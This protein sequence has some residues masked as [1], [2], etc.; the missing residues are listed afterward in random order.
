[1]YTHI[2]PRMVIN[3]LLADDC[4]QEKGKQEGLRGCSGVNC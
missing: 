4:C 2:V 3:V 1:M